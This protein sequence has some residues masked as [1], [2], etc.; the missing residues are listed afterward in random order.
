[1]MIHINKFE[2]VLSQKRTEKEKTTLQTL[3]HHVK[4]SI[5]Q[6]Q[7]GALLEVWKFGSLGQRS[8]IYHKCP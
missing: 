4:C 5:E 3:H 6:D 7:N 2:T 8:Q 1:M